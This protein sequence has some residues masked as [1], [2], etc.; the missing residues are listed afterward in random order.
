MVSSGVYAGT[1]W[2]YPG[3]RSMM[4]KAKENCHAPFS[5]RPA[6]LSQTTLKTRGFV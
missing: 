6:S 2:A 1:T 5:S 3:F 4:D